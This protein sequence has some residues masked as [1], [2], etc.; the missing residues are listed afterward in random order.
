MLFL[1]VSRGKYLI[2]PLIGI[3]AGG[4]WVS[5]Y[6]LLRIELVA[7]GRIDAAHFHFDPNAW[8][9]DSTLRFERMLK[10]LAEQAREGRI[11]VGDAIRRSWLDPLENT[12]ADA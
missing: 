3:R 11:D 2:N 1:R 9:E 7:P 4:E 8:R 6:D 12:G 5:I 10:G